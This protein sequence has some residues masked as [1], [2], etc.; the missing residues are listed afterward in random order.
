MRSAN[1]RFYDLFGLEPGDTEGRELSRLN[2]R[3]DGADIS[4]LVHDVLT[5][6]EPVER[7]VV[8]DG[9]ANGRRRLRFRANPLPL[10]DSLPGVL[11]TIEDLG[12]GSGKA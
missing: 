2:R 9:A 7:V 11:I 3:L 10:D 4:R 12:D 1:G 6:H 8:H 5:A